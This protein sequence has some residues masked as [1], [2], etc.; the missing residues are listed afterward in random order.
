[1]I[2]LKRLSDV[3]WS[4]H[5]E[6]TSRDSVQMNGGDLARFV[7]AVGL[8]VADGPGLCDGTFEMVKGS[9]AETLTIMKVAGVR[10]GFTDLDQTV[11]VRKDRSAHH[12]AVTEPKD[13]VLQGVV[14][15]GVLTLR[16][17]QRQP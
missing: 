9:H 14:E 13:T 12:T 11:V 17:V 1:M 5:K 15:V 2:H 3:L 16:L 6:T 7:T 8:T 4:E 10:V